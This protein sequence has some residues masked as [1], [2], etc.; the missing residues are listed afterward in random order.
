[1]GRTNIVLQDELVKKAMNLTGARTKREVVNLA[2]ER[3]VEKGSLY[4]SLKALKGK[5]KWEGDP[6]AWRSNRR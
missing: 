2:L 3:V 5:L 4:R 6:A 1:M